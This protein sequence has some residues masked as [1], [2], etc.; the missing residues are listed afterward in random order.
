MKEYFDKRGTVVITFPERGFT[1]VVV[2]RTTTYSSALVEKM[3][4]TFDLIK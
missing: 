2:V 1:V 3:I 4:E